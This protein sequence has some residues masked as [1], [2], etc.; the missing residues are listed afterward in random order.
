MSVIESVPS[1]FGKT[2]TSVSKEQTT[3]I[4]KITTACKNITQLQTQPYTADF[5]TYTVEWAAIIKVATARYIWGIQ[6]N[7]VV[8]LENTDAPIP[9]YLVF[10][11]HKIKI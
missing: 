7:H 9:D 11:I 3:E 5:L 10:L 4:I 8:F 1:C 2:C 6:I